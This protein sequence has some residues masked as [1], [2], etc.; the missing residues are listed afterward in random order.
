MAEIVGSLVL[1]QLTKPVDITKISIVKAVEALN[2]YI[3]NR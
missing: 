3:N 1:R 2:Y